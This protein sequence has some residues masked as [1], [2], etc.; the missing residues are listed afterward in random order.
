MK[1]LLQLIDKQIFVLIAWITAL[2]TLASIIIIILTS[3]LRDR[4][5][6][7]NQSDFQIRQI[8]SHS[9]TIDMDD[10][11]LDEHDIKDGITYPIYQRQRYWSDDEVDYYWI[12]PDEAGIDSLSDENDRLIYESLGIEW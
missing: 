8:L 11:Y 10:F 3:D 6:A 12:D 7:V 2:V 1:R 4:Y 5:A 9:T